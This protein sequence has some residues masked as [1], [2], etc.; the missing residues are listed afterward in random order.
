MIIAPVILPLVPNPSPSDCET[1]LSYTS[2][3][4]SGLE[5]ILN[6]LY[7]ASSDPDEAMMLI[8]EQVETMLSEAGNM[9]SNLNSIKTEA[10]SK[11]DLFSQGQTEA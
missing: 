7:E 11:M 10:V 9:K 1:L 2:S 8:R 5:S 3:V 4:M 6:M